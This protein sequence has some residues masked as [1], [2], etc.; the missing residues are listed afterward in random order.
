LAALTAALSGAARAEWIPPGPTCPLAPLTYIPLWNIPTN[1]GILCFVGN[2]P[3]APSTTIF[4]VAVVPVII[5]LLDTNGNVQY[6]LDPTKPLYV[7]VN[8]NAQFSAYDAMNN[9]PIFGKEKYVLGGTTIGTVQW[10]EATERASFWKYTGTAF[11]NWHV[12]M[13]TFPITPSETLKVPNGKWYFLSNPNTYGVDGSVLDPFLLKIAQKYPK[14]LPILLTYNI[15]EDTTKLPVPRPGSPNGCCAFGYHDLYTI[16]GFTSFF[17]WGSYLDAPGYGLSDL[18][19][20]SHEVAEFMNDPTVG[21]T[22]QPWPAPFSFTLPWNPPYNFTKCQGN[23]EVGDALE[24]RSGSELLYQINTS[25]MTYHF[26]NEALDSWF[27]QAKPSF[28][29]NGWYTMKGAVDG[30]FN[31][32]APVC[33]TQ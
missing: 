31:S 10:G 12:G 7:P 21:N 22:V 28:S 13:A 9:S 15:G 8:S 32:P 27:M 11:K 33:P 16:G 18:G 5:K 4:E 14:S 23:L 1:T 24:D 3:T 26:Q 17:I 6:T 25:I 30:E 29:V 19:A 2:P 20:M